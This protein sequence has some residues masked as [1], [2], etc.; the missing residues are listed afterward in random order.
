MTRRP[1]I[2]RSSILNLQEITPAAILWAHQ[3]RREHK[4]LVEQIIKLEQSVAQVKTDTDVVNE[5]TTSASGSVEGFGKFLSEIKKQVEGLECKIAEVRAM[6]EVVT[7]EAKKI[8]EETRHLEEAAA[9]ER[10]AWRENLEQR[11]MDKIGKLRVE[12]EEIKRADEISRLPSSVSVPHIY[13][14]P[15]VPPSAQRPPLPSTISATPSSFQPRCITRPPSMELIP[16]S[17][18]LPV[19]EHSTRACIEC[20]SQISTAWEPSQHSPS[21]TARQQG[22]ITDKDDNSPILNQHNLSL[23]AY[24]ELG[25]TSLASKFP[26][27]RDESRVVQAF[28]EGMRDPSDKRTIEESLE[29]DGWS[30]SSLRA[31]VGALVMKKEKNTEKEMQKGEFSPALKREEAKTEKNR[32]RKRKRVI[33]LV[34]PSEDEEYE[35]LAQMNGWRREV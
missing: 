32:L 16:N 8:H 15:L 27:K 23:L 13:S 5:R 22:P 6:V 29:Q 4:A 25:E 2:A 24:L 35:L 30:W 14:S 3:L 9:I 33:P 19:M 1:S 20:A 31:A 12:I 34:W 10:L 18:P 21:P 7:Q 17:Y 28:W 11:C 26:R